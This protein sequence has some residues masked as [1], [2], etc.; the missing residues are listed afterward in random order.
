MNAPNERGH[1]SAQGS[2]AVAETLLEA[3]ELTGSTLD[4][5]VVQSALENAQRIIERERTIPLTR[6]DAA[7]LLDLLDSP[8]APNEAMTRAFAR[9]KRE[10]C[11]A[12]SA[13]PE[14]GA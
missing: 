2:N 12:A 4:Q 13:V 6:E 14:S 10:K 3:A 7:F 11:D 1:I 8:P 9:Y 5:F